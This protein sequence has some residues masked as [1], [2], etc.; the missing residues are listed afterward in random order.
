MNVNFV[1]VT[2]DE[3]HIIETADV[4]DHKRFWIEWRQASNFIAEARSMGASEPNTI[5]KYITLRRLPDGRYFAT[6]CV[7]KDSY[8]PVR[9]NLSYVIR[10]T[11]KLLP[12]QPPAV[13][14]LCDSLLRNHAAADGSATGIGKTYH[15]LAVCRE[16][17]YRPVIVCRKSGFSNWKRACEYFE[18]EPYLIVN[19]ELLRTG[20]ISCLSKNEK[21]FT[22]TLPDDALI[23]FDEAHLACNNGTLNNM[24]YMA[25][26]PFPTLSCSAT[27]ADRPVRLQALFHMLGVI[28]YNRFHQWL[29]NTGHFRNM[30][31]QYESIAETVD[32]KRINKILYPAFGYRL[33]YD[34]P[35]VR[36]VYSHPVYQVEI[37][38]IEGE[39]MQNAL[40]NDTIR[41]M[42]RY[43]ESKQNAQAMNADMRYRQIAELNKVG[44]IVERVRDY[45]DEGL[46]VCIFVNFRETLAH[47]AKCLNT[48]SLIFGE[49]ERL[50]IDRDKVI[51]DFQANRERLLIAT[52]D[53]GGESI[54]LHDLH[55]SHRRISLIC[56]TYSAIKLL[57]VMGRTHR[58]GT[59]T[60]PIIKLLYAA[61]TIEEKVARMVNS[62]LDNISALNDGDLMEPDLFNL[63]KGA[64]D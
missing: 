37:V 8:K 44:P 45:I 21:S 6:R 49:Q 47:L 34:D 14:H 3:T 62:K 42:E 4:T 22:W 25:S 1:P 9:F 38:T 43:R 40:Y 61:G 35:Q 54:N 20:R 18:I 27:F 13:A 56:P 7:N 15:A 29:E 11:D 2:E 33:S 19:W 17:S 59:K 16:L 41:I 58:S 30:L 46:S 55:G 32:M 52:V 63:R 31:D 10:Y 26:K 5:H 24:L 57:Q 48:R 60:I 28:P 23:V 53:A 12:F 51:D 36:K 39:K 50:N 64:H